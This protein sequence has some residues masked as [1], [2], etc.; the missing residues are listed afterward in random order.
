M[1]WISMNSK[2]YSP[3]SGPGLVPLSKI[4]GLSH[5]PIMN[6]KKSWSTGWETEEAHDELDEVIRKMDDWNNDD[7]A[8]NNE[9]IVEA[10]YSLKKMKIMDSFN[11]DLL[12]M[13]TNS[14]W[15]Q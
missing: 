6:I 1:D 11:V 9:K 14:N 4:M 3:Q 12:S 8:K 7:Q 10:E 13:R 15:R 5:A 2:N